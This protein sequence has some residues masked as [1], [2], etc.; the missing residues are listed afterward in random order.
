MIKFR[1]ACTNVKHE[2]L[3][4]RSNYVI[5]LHR[6]VGKGSVFFKAFQQRNRSNDRTNFVK[7]ALSLASRNIVHIKSAKQLTE[8]SLLT[9]RYIQYIIISL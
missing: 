3:N 7:I 5:N 2:K 4:I 9:Q 6:K 1:K 8:I